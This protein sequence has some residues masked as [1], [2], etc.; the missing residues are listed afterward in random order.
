MAFYFWTV[1]A[2]AVAITLTTSPGNAFKVSL[3]ALVLVS[4]IGLP[5]LPA[6]FRFPAG[7]LA[8]FNTPSIITTSNLSP[9][10]HPWL[11]RMLPSSHN[12]VLPRLDPSFLVAVVRSSLDTLANALPR[13]VWISTTNRLPCL[14]TL[15][16]LIVF[17]VFFIISTEYVLTP[18]DPPRQTRNPRN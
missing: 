16:P 5:T 7:F 9:V 10:C 2:S 6:T 13:P 17:S 18:L 3:M 15:R 11:L 8:Y 12:L 4:I 1:I 14:M